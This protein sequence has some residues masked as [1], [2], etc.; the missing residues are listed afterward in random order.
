LQHRQVESGK[1]GL[2]K[3]DKESAYMNVIVAR[4]DNKDSQKV[5]NFIKSISV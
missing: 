3:E 2:L 5:K 1:N 4:E